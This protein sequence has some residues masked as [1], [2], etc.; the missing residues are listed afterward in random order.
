MV[1]V[2][3]LDLTVSDPGPSNGPAAKKRRVESGWGLLKEQLS[4]TPQVPW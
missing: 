1:E 4:G 2:T 3:S